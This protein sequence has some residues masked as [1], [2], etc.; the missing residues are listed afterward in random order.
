MIVGLALLEGTAFLG[1]L[2]YLIEAQPLALG[3]TG[4]AILCMLLKFP[5]R[6]RVQAWLERQTEQL[7][8]LRQ[9]M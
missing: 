7:T 5:T 1:I 9:K 3:V 8:E 6:S 4:I 2:A